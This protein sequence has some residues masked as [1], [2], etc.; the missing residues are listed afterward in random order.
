MA[1]N[2]DISGCAPENRIITWTTVNP[3]SIRITADQ[4]ISV[5]A[6][7][8]VSTGSAADLVVTSE[9]INDICTVGAA[10]HVVTLGANNFAPARNGRGVN[11]PIYDTGA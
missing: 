2:E 11:L 1:A 5:A 6:L 4:V 10:D 9:A 8:R 7:N 3:I